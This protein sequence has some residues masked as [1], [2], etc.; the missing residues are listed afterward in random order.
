M[1]DPYA[2]LGV[3]HDATQDEIAR[4]YRR[5][6]R[7][8]HPDMR[9]GTSESHSGHDELQQV[10]AAYTLLRDPDRRAAFDRTIRVVEVN[11]ADERAVVRGVFVDSAPGEA[12][13]LWA[14]PVRW[15]R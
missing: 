4:A 14:G 15:H 11:P 9:S 13:P 6:L 5:Q 3:P 12:P 10:L 8:H 1:L 2:V 7:N